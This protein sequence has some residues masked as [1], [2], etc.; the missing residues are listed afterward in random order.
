MN[1]SVIEEKME[2]SLDQTSL[3]LERAQELTWCQNKSTRL[4]VAYE[5]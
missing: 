5:T 4:A 3:S 2:K 1:D